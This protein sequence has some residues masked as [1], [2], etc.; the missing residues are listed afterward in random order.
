M[1]GRRT[2]NGRFD[3]GFEE[4]MR[5]SHSKANNTVGYWLPQAARSAGPNGSCEPRTA[6]PAASR[7][8]GTRRKVTP[9]RPAWTSTTAYSA[10]PAIRAGGLPGKRSM[11]RNQGDPHRPHLKPWSWATEWVT[12][13]RV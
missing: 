2:L 10:V 1:T 8:T 13:V 3:V 12:A 7:L 9:T 6:A 4:R 11:S 5:G